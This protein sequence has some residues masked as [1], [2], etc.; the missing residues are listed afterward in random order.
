MPRCEQRAN[1]PAPREDARFSP[2][3]EKAETSPAAVISTTASKTVTVS[4]PP[5]GG[6]GDGD[7]GAAGGRAGGGMGPQVLVAPFELW[8]LM[9]VTAL[10]V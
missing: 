4:P 6:G 5:P 9:A 3:R 10:P 7:H 2:W 8:G 1:G